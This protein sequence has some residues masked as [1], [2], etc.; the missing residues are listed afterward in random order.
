M[1]IKLRG[2][3]V[4]LPGNPN[5]L[6]RLPEWNIPFGSR[7]LIH[8]PSGSGK[9]TLLH[10]LSGQ[11]LPE[12][13]EIEVG[14]Y[15]FTKMSEDSRCYLRRKHFGIIFQSLNLFPHFNVDENM[16]LGQ[17]KST[18]D[19]EGK[20]KLALSRVGL[21]S[22]SLQRCGTMSLGEQQRGAVARVLAFSPD[23]IL[24]DEPT[25][26]LDHI[27]AE[28]VITALLDSS[29]RGTVVVVS[30]DERIKLAFKSVLSFTDLV[31]A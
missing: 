15:C 24:A 1:D 8:G 2:I 17:L 30:H 14:Q 21:K 3:H 12:E 19:C 25:S 27:N 23:I 16:E 4:H 5:P 31:H 20:N 10:L 22:G 6:F 13:G 29:N 9:T 28:R 18:K 7:I 11:L 26:S